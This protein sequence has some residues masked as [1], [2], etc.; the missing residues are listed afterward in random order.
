MCLATAGIRSVA[1]SIVGRPH[2]LHKRRYMTKYEAI[3]E[4]NRL[5]LPWIR[6]KNAYHKSL[7]IQRSWDLF[8]GYLLDEGKITQKQHDLWEKP[9]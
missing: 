9:K 8:K 1:S 7:A 2:F 4:F 6:I 5:A 3:E